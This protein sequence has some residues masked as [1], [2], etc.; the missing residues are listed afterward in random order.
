MKKDRTKKKPADRVVDFLQSAIN[1]SS[2]GLTDVPALIE[3]VIKEE[4]WRERY[5][6]PTKEIV[7]FDDFADFT[8]S[9]PP[10]GLG[11]TLKSLYKFCSESPRTV[12]LINEVIKRPQRGGD[13]RSKQFKRNNVTPEKPNSRGNS[14]AYSLK[15]LREARPDLHGKVLTGEI[16]INKAIIQ[17][18]FR[19]KPLILPRDVE[20]L[21][22]LI[23]NEFTQQDIKLL[24]SIFNK[25]IY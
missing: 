5:V 21:A 4:I 7:R 12:D 8:T 6:A 14:A 25:E 24:I 20:K 18:G 16:S 17:A 15:R 13:R 9:P 19:K 11:T 2:R 22:E 3:R 1:D 10:E 23:K